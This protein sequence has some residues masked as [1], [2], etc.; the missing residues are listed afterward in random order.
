MVVAVRSWVVKQE[1]AQ[2]VVIGDSV[3]EAWSALWIF[4]FPSSESWPMDFFPLFW[5]ST[6]WCDNYR[7]QLGSFYLCSF[8]A[9]N[10]S[11]LSFS[12]TGAMTPSLWGLMAGI[13]GL[14]ATGWLPVLLG[15]QLP[16]YVMQ[17]QPS[18]NQAVGGSQSRF[19]EIFDRLLSKGPIAFNL[20]LPTNNLL[21]KTFL[22]V[23][24]L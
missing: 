4:Q 2:V 9:C 19:L 24:R 18:Q 8:L 14:P 17:V 12:V 6:S 13:L 21:F 1:I 10:L 23:L 20:L 22:K 16:P 7:I 15:T 3:A 5:D 11:P